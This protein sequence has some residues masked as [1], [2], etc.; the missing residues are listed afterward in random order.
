MIFISLCN[1]LVSLFCMQL[2][3]NL[4]LVYSTHPSGQFYTVWLTSLNVCV[5]KF[6]ISTSLR[7]KLDVIAIKTGCILTNNSVSFCL[8]GDMGKEWW[9]GVKERIFLWKLSNS[10]WQ[11]NK[12]WSVWKEIYQHYESRYI[13]QN[14][15][16]WKGAA[17]AEEPTKPL[18]YK[19]GKFKIIRLL[20]QPATWNFLGWNYTNTSWKNSTL[21]RS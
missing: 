16:R 14:I 12:F 2:C 10:D 8:F 1:I 11:D 15:L 9:C 7:C 18:S 17:S 13:Y 5:T 4:L 21:L 6:T 19:A 20:L 3:T